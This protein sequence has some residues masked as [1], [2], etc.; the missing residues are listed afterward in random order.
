MAKET[1]SRYIPYLKL[2]E[3]KFDAKNLPA[4]FKG[5]Y[6]FNKLLINGVP[7]LAINVKDKKL[8]PREFKKHAQILKEKIK[9]PQIWCLHEL[10][11]HKVQRMIQNGLNFIVEGKQVHLPGLSI[12]IKPEMTAIKTN[13]SHL[14]GLAVNIL[15]REVLKGD[16]SG[17]NKLG[18]ANI[19]DVTQMTAG[20]AIEPLVANNLCF[21]KKEGVSKHIFFHNKSDLWE[22]LK[23]QIESPVKEI[24]H[25][26]KIPKGLPYSGITA[27]SKKTMLADDRIP[28]FAVNKKEFKKTISTKHIAL[29]D[30]ATA[31]IEL[32]DRTPI[33]LEKACVNPID[34]FLIN[35]TNRDERVQIELENLL[36]NII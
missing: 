13:T 10:H 35:Q 27:L 30:F 11:F 19:F 22:Y 25:V 24:V 34:I 5:I 23:T 31:K 21:E 3:T 29:E 32:W 20:R 26:D 9:Y 7:Y 36:K 14:N 18:L 15:I 6:D 1:I 16:L 17:E 12:S 28:T 8:G 2:T 33:L 4:F